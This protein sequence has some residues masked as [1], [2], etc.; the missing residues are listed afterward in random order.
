[1][2]DKTTVEVKVGY[3]TCSLLF[4]TLAVLK[5]THMINW[6]WWWVTAPVWAPLAILALIAIILGIALLFTKD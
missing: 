2:A 4:V 1:M 6:S 3:I 5:L